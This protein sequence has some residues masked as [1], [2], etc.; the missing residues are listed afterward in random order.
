MA[1]EHGERVCNLKPSVNNKSETGT[2]V[3]FWPEPKYF[4][5]PKIQTKHLK[6]IL[7]AKAV[8]C[9]GLK[10]RFEDT[11]NKEVVEWLYEAGLKG[12]LLEHVNW[13]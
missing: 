5:N 2:M 7:Q 6:H 1:F 12:Y 3:R 4:D 11:Q 9:P 13:H 8:L 10:V